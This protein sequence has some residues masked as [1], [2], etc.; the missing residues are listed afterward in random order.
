MSEERGSSMIEVISVIGII[1][2]L[3]IGVW[4]LIGSARYRYKVSQ[5]IMQLQTLQKGINRF[6]ASDGNY[7]RLGDSDAIE[8]LFENRIIPKEMKRADNK[9]KNVFGNEVTIKKLDNSSDSFVIAFKS[10]ERKVC[11][12]MAS[13]SWLQNDSA[14]LVSIKI[15][16][17]DVENG[18]NG[19][20]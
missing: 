10:V 19:E 8:K 1:A 13:I 3:A 9:V 4:N 12:E 15:V 7:N 2:I 11:L 17:H 20:N 14:N 6:Y 16:G 18:E 5:G